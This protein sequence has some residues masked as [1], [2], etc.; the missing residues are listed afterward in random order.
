MMR[1]CSRRSQ[2]A[3]A[4]PGSGGDQVRFVEKR[5]DGASELYPLTD[6][7]PRQEHNLARRYL[8]GAYGAVPILDGFDLLKL[9]CRG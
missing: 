8:G 3:R 4:R 7:K 9:S 2:G 1:M 5:T 6:F